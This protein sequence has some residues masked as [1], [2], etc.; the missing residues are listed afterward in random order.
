LE[1]NRDIESAEFRPPEDRPGADDVSEGM[2]DQLFATM[3]K[4]SKDSVLMAVHK[5][6]TS[7][8][9]AW[10]EDAKSALRSVLRVLHS[11]ML[12]L[13]FGGWTQE[14][15]SAIDEF[16]RWFQAVQ[17]GIVESNSAQVNELENEAS[18]WQDTLRQH[19]DRARKSYLSGIVAHGDEVGMDSFWKDV[20]DL[21]RDSA[22]AA[23]SEGIEGPSLGRFRETLGLAR[24]GKLAIPVDN[25]NSRRL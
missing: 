22:E 10:D 8:D 4:Y 5:L 19:L 20:Y 21:D 2:K 17:A 6:Y 11:E 25:G 14:Q 3:S 1:T 18:K 15:E 16:G 13:E 7:H 12:R 9:L 24:E 23:Y